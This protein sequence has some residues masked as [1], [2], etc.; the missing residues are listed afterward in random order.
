MGDPSGQLVFLTLLGGS[1]T[2]EGNCID[3]DGANNIYVAGETVSPDFPT[4]NAWQS[5]PTVLEDA[6]VFKLTPDGTLVYSTYI[7]GSSSDEINDI[8]VDSV[9]N[10]Y[11]GGEVYSDDFPLLNPWMSETY[12]ESDEDGFISIFNPDGQFSG[13]LEG[14]A[15]HKNDRS[16]RSTGQ[17]DLDR[18]RN[19]LCFQDDVYAREQNQPEEK[20]ASRDQ[21][22]FIRGS[23]FQRRLLQLG[24]TPGDADQV[25][26]R[27][28]KIE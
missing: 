9:G 8:Y 18:G 17:L 12:G 27:L 13:G 6:Y 1:K 20:R 3:V 10:T 14:A 22:R 11:I 7:G 26:C 2:E 16:F 23:E 28:D 19:S 5:H 25:V 15:F 24:E 21:D 4:R